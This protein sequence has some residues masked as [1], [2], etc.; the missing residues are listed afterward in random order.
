MAEIVAAEVLFVAEVLVVA[1]WVD[2]TQGPSVGWLPP[3]GK[4]NFVGQSEL[5]SWLLKKTIFFNS[6]S[7]FCNPTASY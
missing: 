7:A 3:Q 6:L 2:Q 5:P 4:L 1:A